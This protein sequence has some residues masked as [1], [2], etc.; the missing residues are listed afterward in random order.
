MPQKQNII[1]RGAEAVLIRKDSHLLKRRIPKKYRHPALDAQL[2]TRRTKQEA[3]I[4]EKASK[5]VSVPRVLHVREDEIDMEF[6]PGKVLS[7]NLDSFPQKQQSEIAQSLGED[8]ARLHGVNI[9][10]GDL[11]TSNLILK[12]KQIFFIDFGL[13]FHSER[14]EDKAVDVHLLQEALKSKHFRIAEKFFAIFAQAYSK[15]YKKGREVLARMKEVE[16]R[17]RYKKKGML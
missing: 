5:L 1:A 4:L 12:G 13:G 14:I 8:V 3:R 11:T 7:E 15:N 2:R 6:I 9:I 10:H 16:S 17:G